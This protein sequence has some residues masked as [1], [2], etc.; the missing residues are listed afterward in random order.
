MLRTRVPVAIA[1]LTASL[2]L[3]E[4]PHKIIFLEVQPVD[5]ASK[6]VAELLGEAIL[7]DLSKVRQVSVLGSS[8]LAALLGVERQ[9]QL[10]GCRED[11]S[12]CLAELGGALGAS[13]IL[14]GKMGRVGKQ[15]RVDLKLL[16]SG[17]A[18][19][20]GREG[21]LIASEDELVPLTRT[22][23]ANLLSTLPG[24]ENARTALH[25]QSE[26]PRGPSGG[27]VAGFAVA[28]VGVASIV[29]GALLRGS[30]LSYNE[31]R[32]ELTSERA[33]LELARAQEQ[34]TL[35]GWMLA[36]GGAAVLAG[37]AVVW[38][39]APAQ[40]AVVLLLPSRRGAAA[41]LAISF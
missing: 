33:Q 21:F 27:Q 11:E 39:A 1:L 9:R 22:A 3:A 4:A 37:A 30:A 26:A 25:L 32:L 16:A 41:V 15:L 12:S 6:G 18:Q 13:Y 29:G 34:L 36:G 38:L 2:S 7:T 14:M 17:R 40:P 19:V 20:L 5:E 35:G 24:V 10:L 8:D 28:G 23:L 31:R